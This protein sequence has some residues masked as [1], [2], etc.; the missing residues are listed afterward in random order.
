MKCCAIETM[1]DSLLHFFVAFHLLLTIFCCRWLHYSLWDPSDWPFS[2]HIH[3]LRSVT[4]FQPIT[5]GRLS[6]ARRWLTKWPVS[7]FLGVAAE[8]QLSDSEAELRTQTAERKVGRWRPW[9]QR[10]EKLTPTY[11][12]GL[13]FDGD[14]YVF[15]KRETPNNVCKGQMSAVFPLTRPDLTLTVNP[16]CF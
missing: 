4:R 6:V 7:R 5:R 9:E 12:D 1:N 3:E 8:G 10:C 16:V 2:I 14:R 15:P 13:I 11:K